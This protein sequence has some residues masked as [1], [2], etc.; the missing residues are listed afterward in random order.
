MLPEYLL[1]SRCI[2]IS[3]LERERMSRK[4]KADM[5][6]CKRVIWKGEGCVLNVK[7]DVDVP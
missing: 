3:Q 2:S 7:V 5:W 1:G 4:V 6:S